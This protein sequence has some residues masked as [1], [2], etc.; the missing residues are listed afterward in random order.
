MLHSWRKSRPGAGEF[1]PASSWIF[2][3]TLPPRSSWSHGGIILHSSTAWSCSY[4]VRVLARGFPGRTIGSRPSTGFWRHGKREGACRALQ[5]LNPMPYK[6]V[7][8]EPVPQNVQRIRRHMRDN[9]I[10][11]DDQWIIE[12]A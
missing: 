1:R 9:G 5:L 6:L 3:E 12:G 2:S 8:V 11:P 10:D 7:A 4:S